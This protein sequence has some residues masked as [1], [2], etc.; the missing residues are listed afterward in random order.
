MKVPFVSF[1]PMEKELDKQLRDAFD[2]VLT[3]SWYIEGQE[4][5]AFEKAFADYCGT[6]YCIGVGNGLDALMLVLKSLGVGEVLACH[7]ELVVD[8]EVREVLS[9]YGS[10]AGAQ[11]VGDVVA[12]DLGIVAYHGDAVRGFEVPAPSFDAEAQLCALGL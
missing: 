10:H 4:D 9:C 1:L 11:Y 3:R 7:L 2:R 6:D 12:L 8:V 5:Q